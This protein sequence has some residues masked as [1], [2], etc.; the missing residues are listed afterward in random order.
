MKKIILIL[1]TSA[2]LSC[3]G[4]DN[5]S[6]Q[7]NTYFNPPEWIQG[8]FKQSSDANLGVGFKFTDNDFCNVI[9][10]ATQCYKEQLQSFSNVGGVADVEETI[11]DTEYAVEITLQSSTVYYRFLKISSTKIMWISSSGNFELNKQ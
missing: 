2:T 1:I 10:N 3:S 11:T 5:K 4:D 9:V 7:N 6:S 8:T